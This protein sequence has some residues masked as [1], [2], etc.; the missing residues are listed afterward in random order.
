MEKKT[1]ISNIQRF[2]LDDGEGIRTT[3]FFKGCNL[4]CK[5]CHNP[6]C[7]SAE[8]LLQYHENKC[9]NCKKCEEICPIGCHSF[10]NGKHLIDR[11]KCEGC[12]K[13]TEICPGSALEINGKY[14]T[15]EALMEII[16]KD[17]AYY[18]NSGGGVTFSGGEPM[19]SFSV[20]KDLLMK[21][22]SE[23][24]RTA[25]DTAGNI[26]YERYEALFP[27]VDMFLIDLKIWDDDKLKTYTGGSG[28]RIKENIK[29]IAEAGKRVIIR[30]PVIGSVN[31]EKEE[32]KK[33]A[34]F[35]KDIGK[36]ELVQLLPYH[37]YGIGK[38]AISGIKSE[39][40][41]FYVPSSSFMNEM[42]ELFRA[43]GLNT[44]F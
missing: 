32:L 36:I 30:I 12:G 31:D 33:M 38:Y 37:Q 6:E 24:I 27:Y 15:S 40:A 22:K 7:I 2:S 23:N 26:P 35:L 5:W 4:S 3:V 11:Q 19:L 13:C 34:D 21:C 1:L 20:L 25:V 10:E 28:K 29:L 17:C 9:A 43:I 16:K 42:L 44:S 18:E 8:K 14:Y 39:Q 41:D